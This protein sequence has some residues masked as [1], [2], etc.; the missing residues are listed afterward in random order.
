MRSPSRPIPAAVE[1]WTR[2]AS[3]LRA[4]D[5]LA[6]W[7]AGWIALGIAGGWSTVSEPAIL[8]AVLVACAAFLRPLRVRWRPVSA[9]VGVS[10]ARPLRP[11]DR[12]WFV[13]PRQ[14]EPVIVTARRGLRF[15]VAQPGSA[16][17][18][19]EVRASRVILLP[20]ERA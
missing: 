3:A 15:V 18:G 20:D 16:S 10:V 14:A 6:G 12:A 11:G 7:V 8:A 13:R 2:W 1:R 5:A 4:A 17:E 9:W 19:L